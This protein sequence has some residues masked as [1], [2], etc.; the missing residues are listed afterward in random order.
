VV[1]AMSSSVS[2]ATIAG[3]IGL[4]ELEDDDRLQADIADACI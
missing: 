3:A 1:M 2:T 4:D